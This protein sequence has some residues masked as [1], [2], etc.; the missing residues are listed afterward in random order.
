MGDVSNP[1]TYKE[2]IV[3]PQSNFWIDAMKD[4][5]TSM[6]Q[7]KVWSFVDLSY[8]YRPIGCK[9]VFKIKMPRDKYRD[10]M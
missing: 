2:V 10:I 1:T 6:S 8:D 4:E 5:T 3:S 7:N 9:W